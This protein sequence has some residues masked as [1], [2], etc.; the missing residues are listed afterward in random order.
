M[1]PTAKDDFVAYPYLQIG[2][3]IR[4]MKQAFTYFMSN[5]LKEPPAKTKES[6]LWYYPTIWCYLCRRRTRGVK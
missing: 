4:N 1:E 2:A 6:S 5:N 3:G